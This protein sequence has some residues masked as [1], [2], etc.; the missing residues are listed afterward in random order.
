[1]AH[2]RLEYTNYGLIVPRMQMKYA[3]FVYEHLEV[4]FLIQDSA[5][6]GRDGCC[7]EVG[8]RGHGC[9]GVESGRRRLLPLTST[10]GANVNAAGSLTGPFVDDDELTVGPLIDAILNLFPFHRIGYTGPIILIADDTGLQEQL[11]I[12]AGGFRHN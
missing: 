9:R 11:V 3:D 7:I 12:K 10:Y 4:Y 5:D 1:M 2:N 8:G 6:Q